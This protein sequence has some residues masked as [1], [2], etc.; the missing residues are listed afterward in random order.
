MAL[1]SSPVPRGGI[2]GV[3]EEEVEA[4]KREGGGGNEASYTFPSLGVGA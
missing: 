2:G 4:P 1:R 3:V